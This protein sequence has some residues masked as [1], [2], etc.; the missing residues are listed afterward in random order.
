LAGDRSREKA[1]WDDCVRVLKG[2]E[3]YALYHS[4]RYES[5]CFHCIR[6]M[7]R[8]EEE[9]AALDCI[10]ARSCNILAAVYSHIH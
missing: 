6:Q 9:A 8:T 3:D 4:G 10:R 2:F 5:Q 1:V 7:A